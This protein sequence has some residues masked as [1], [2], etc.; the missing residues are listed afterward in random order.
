MY[1]DSHTHKKAHLVILE[2]GDISGSRNSSERYRYRYEEGLLRESCFS[3]AK[4]KVQNAEQCLH[5]VT[6]NEQCL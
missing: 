4:T 1:K 2:E 3:E 6:G 5:S